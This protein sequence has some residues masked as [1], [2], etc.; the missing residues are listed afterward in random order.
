MLERFYDISHL[1]TRQLQE[2]YAKKKKKGWKDF[3]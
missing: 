1:S 2:L 3:D